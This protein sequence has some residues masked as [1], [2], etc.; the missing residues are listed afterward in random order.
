MLYEFRNSDINKVIFELN[1]TFPGSATDFLDGSCLFYQGE[2]FVGIVDYSAH[3]AAGILHSGDVMTTVS[4]HHDMR[5]QL[6][7]IPKL[8]D[9][10]FFALSAYNCGNLSLFRNPS[11][12]VYD[13][14]QPTK[15]L[16]Q[17]A[18]SSAGSSSAVIMCCLYRS[19]GGW[20]VSAVGRHSGGTVRDY[21]QMKH[22]CLQLIRAQTS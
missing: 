1:W 15:Q 18:I 22:T 17:Y 5:I 20:E 3:Q 19:S 13:E 9:R 11:V 12:K 2:A 21:G 14:R 7:A 16:C 8:I 6:D 10:L 4:G